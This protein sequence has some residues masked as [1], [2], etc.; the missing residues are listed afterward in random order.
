LRGDDAAARRAFLYSRK[1]SRRDLKTHLWAIEYAVSQNDVPGALR[2]YDLALRTSR[3]ASDILFPVL[4]GAIPDPN[5]R[6]ALLP[7]LLK[8][9]V[10]AGPFVNYL[11]ISSPDHRSAAALFGA[12][13][14]AGFAFPE[15]AEASLLGALVTSRDYAIADHYLTQKD[16]RRS[17]ASSRDPNFSS[18]A[19]TPSPFDWNPQNDVGVTSSI[20]PD[21]QGGVATFSS[22]AGA[23]GPALR[24]LQLLPPGRYEIVSRLSVLSESSAVPVW[25]VQCVDGG[26]V[27][28][29]PLRM[30]GGGAPVSNGSFTIRSG[31]PAQWLTLIVEPSDAP[32]GVTGELSFAQVRPARGG[33]R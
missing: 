14:S 32:G 25:T 28:R 23:G 21:R 16:G 18:N 9:P 7:I 8:R 11:A 4:A 26:E 6:Q 13:G 31:C 3:Q 33:S 15:G 17:R 20:Q 30:V 19:S 5:I 24:Q 10:W 12:L 29:L 1:V 2:H 27:A 22:V